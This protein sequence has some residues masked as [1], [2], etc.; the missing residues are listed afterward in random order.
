MP[1]PNP[2]LSPP[3][4]ASPSRSPAQDE[5]KHK[6]KK[7]RKKVLKWIIREIKMNYK[8]KKEL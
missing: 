5:G 2:F 8:R 6:K 1:C 3:M 7:D 4:L